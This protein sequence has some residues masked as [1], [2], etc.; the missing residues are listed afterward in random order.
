M[1]IETQKY[2][3]QQTQS[4]AAVNLLSEKLKP[5]AIKVLLKYL[6]KVALK[7]LN[8]SLKNCSKHKYGS[9]DGTNTIS[10]I[11]YAFIK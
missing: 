2:S 7:I 10:R 1:K 3:L 4:K 6:Q 11:R 5:L 8:L 9:I